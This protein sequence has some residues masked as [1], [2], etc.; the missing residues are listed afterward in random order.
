MKAPP[1]NFD[2]YDRGY[3]TINGVT[4]PLTK[5]LWDTLQIRMQRDP[6][7]AR[8][9]FGHLLATKPND[10]YAAVLG[11]D[12]CVKAGKARM[13][14]MSKEELSE[15]QSNAAKARWSKQKVNNG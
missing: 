5:P 6:S 14:S 4:T 2:K 12:S 11:H 8:S 3:V 15:F 9:Q 7:E 1:I 10:V 13:S